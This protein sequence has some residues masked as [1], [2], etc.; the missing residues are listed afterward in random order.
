MGELARQRN[1]RDMWVSRSHL[2]A[3]LTGTILLVG[4]A[5][6]VGFLIGQGPTGSDSTQAV[7]KDQSLVTLLA[8]VEASQ[9]PRSG[10]DDLTFP[11]VLEG[12][13]AAP[14][15][16]AA[17]PAGDGVITAVEGGPGTAQAADPV[18][19]GTHTVVAGRFSD[20]AEANALKAKLVASG[21]PAWSALDIVDG[22]PTIT[23]SVGGYPDEATAKQAV[24][25]M[26]AAV[27]EL[28]LH[29]QVAPIP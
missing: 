22:K 12:Q 16:V 25:D 10:V 6:G 9:R 15:P 19:A 2:Q 8:Q 7:S 5:F 18:P 20:L 21:Q 14:A 17:A 27:E 24:T 28:G 13:P 26:H 4:T 3:M 1:A 23:V 29:P 11:T